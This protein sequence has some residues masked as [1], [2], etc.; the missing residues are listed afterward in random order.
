MTHIF[1]WLREEAVPSGL[2]SKPIDPAF[3]I[4]M[5]E[6]LPEEYQARQKRFLNDQENQPAIL[7]VKKKLKLQAHIARFQYY[8]LYAYS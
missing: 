8:E 1:L 6:R 7:P 2:L 5:Y 4:G 3:D